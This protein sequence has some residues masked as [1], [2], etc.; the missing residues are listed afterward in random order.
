MVTVNE[1]GSPASPRSGASS[2]TETSPG[3]DEDPSV[4]DSPDDDA[5]DDGAPEEEPPDDDA[6]DDEDALPPLDPAASLLDAA[7]A[8]TVDR[9][10]PHADDT[11][12]PAMKD[13]K[14]ARGT[15][16]GMSA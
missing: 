11:S 2:G 14:A 5:S 12:N 3:P 8:E 15:D 16:D 6:P 13:P 1:R 9:D 7:S 10:N 4:D